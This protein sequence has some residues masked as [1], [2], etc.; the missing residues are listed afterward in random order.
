MASPFNLS[1][2]RPTQH[3]YLAHAFGLAQ[4][5][6]TETLVAHKS[7]YRY[8]VPPPEATVDRTTD[9]A[10]A[11]FDDSEWS[12]GH[13]AL[14][15][16][17]TGTLLNLIETDIG[18][19]M[20]EKSSTAYLRTYFEVPSQADWAWIRFQLRYDAG[21]IIYVNGERVASENASTL[22]TSRSRT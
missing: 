18:P 19:V 8:Y 11:E 12:E 15:Y 3:N 22:P 21:Y 13:G 6:L 14:G 17:Q 2:V 20:W 9:W 5:E 7:S 16:D 1:S 4:Q 10:G